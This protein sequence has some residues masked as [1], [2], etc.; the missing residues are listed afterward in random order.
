MIKISR[1]CYLHPKRN[2]KYLSESTPVNCESC[3]ISRNMNYL[4][5][6]SLIHEKGRYMGIVIIICMIPS[7]VEQGP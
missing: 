5:K 7:Q 6:S 2:E 1:S 3:F 4:V